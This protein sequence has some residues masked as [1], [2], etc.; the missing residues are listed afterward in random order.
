MPFNPAQFQANVLQKYLNR[1]YPEIWFNVMALE[2]KERRMAVGNE[3]IKVDPPRIAISFILPPDEK[4]TAAYWGKTI[5]NR[6]NRFRDVFNKKTRCTERKSFW[7]NREGRVALKDL[8]EE[9]YKRTGPQLTLLEKYPKPDHDGPWRKA[10][11]PIQDYIVVNV[12][13]DKIDMW[14]WRGKDNR[15][16]RCKPRR[17]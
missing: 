7:V 15:R 1:V 4:K 2:A 9:A 5:D 13:P 14:L 3:G 6:L 8:H 11:F 12:D 10:T 16:R 17:R